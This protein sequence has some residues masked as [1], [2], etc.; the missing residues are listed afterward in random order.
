MIVDSTTNLPFTNVT[1]ADFYP[2]ERDVAEAYVGAPGREYRLELR[3]LDVGGVEMIAHIRRRLDGRDAIHAAGVALARRA[4]RDPAW[5]H[6]CVDH[7]DGETVYKRALTVSLS[8]EDIDAAVT[9]LADFLRSNSAELE[10]ILD[11][12][13]ATTDVMDDFA[14]DDWS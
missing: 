10:G 13:A 7:R 4:I 6:V 1:A 8:D 11:G 5:S 12:G 9:V 14:L 3:R 2:I